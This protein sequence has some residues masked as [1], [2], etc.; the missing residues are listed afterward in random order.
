MPHDCLVELACLFQS[1]S[2]YVTQ[3][4]YT[5]AVEDRTALYMHTPFQCL[6]HDYS[7][8]IIG[9]NNG[10]QQS[11]GSTK[12]TPWTVLLICDVLKTKRFYWTRWKFH[13]KGSQLCKLNVSWCGVVYSL[14]YRK[15]NSQY[16]CCDSCI[17][18]LYSLMSQ[19]N[20]F[21]WPKDQLWP[22]LFK[23]MP[24]Y[25]LLIDTWLLIAFRVCHA[26]ICSY[27]YHMSWAPS[28]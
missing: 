13:G 24:H 8:C 27:T 5:H 19:A 12:L 21:A 28:W 18:Y 9:M 23:G 26:D 22:I 16:N 3:P 25:C 20:E 7:V 6:S 11:V 2:A 10:Y 4:L 15:D 17:V 1:P 14:A